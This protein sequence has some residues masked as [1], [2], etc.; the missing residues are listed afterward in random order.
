MR[1]ASK[2]Y[3]I[4]IASKR[5]LDLDLEEYLSKPRLCLLLLSN[6]LYIRKE[7]KA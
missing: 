7:Y 2:V 3:A 4:V 5:A 1:I 6:A